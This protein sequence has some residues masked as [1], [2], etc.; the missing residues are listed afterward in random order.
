MNLNKKGFAI[1]SI[2]YSILILFLLL[3]FG[4][5][6]VLGSRKLIFDKMKHD[7]MNDLN[8][9]VVDKQPEVILPNLAQTLRKDCSEERTVGLIKDTDGSCYYQGT[10]EEVSN[11]FVWFAGHLWRVL[12]VNED[13]TLTMITQQPITTI[14][15]QESSFGCWDTQ[16]KYEASYINTWLN[17]VFL[18]SMEI[19]DQSRIQMSTY[20]I[21]PSD[22]IKA[23][24]TEQKVGI[25]DMDEY[26]KGGS[27]DSFLDIKDSFFIGNCNEYSQLQY[28]QQEGYISGGNNW[29]RS[30]SNNGV[31]AVI[32]IAN[33]TFTF[34][35]GTLENP[36][37]EKS[38]TINTSNIKVGEYIELPEMVEDGQT[39][40]YCTRTGHEG[41][42]LFRVVS[43]D[44][45]SIKVILNGVLPNTSAFDENNSPIYTSGNTIDTKV[46]AFA[47]TIDNQYRYTGNKSF[48]IGTYKEG[49]NYTVIQET[50]YTGTW[51][52][53][54]NVGLPVAG[55]MFSGNDIDLSTS[56]TKT[57]VNVNTIE[58]PTVESIWTMNPS[59][60]P[61]MIIINTNGNFSSGATFPNSILGVRPVLFLNKN[62]NF[63][64]G[65]GTAENPFVLE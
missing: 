10:N 39:P 37:R 59:D 21:G 29:F 11:N 23:I 1:S 48:N 9:D 6:G 36:Y 40:Q 5:L 24:Q 53:P 2:I 22:N 60:Q 27:T 57:F 63:T 4:I 8:G 43:K 62:L 31:R 15:A 17:D 55:E 16:E 28:V 25:L 12:T 26:T 35:D 13:D 64:S 42:C 46:T 34:G 50:K 47:N 38:G 61:L 14:Y 51:E 56:L 33:L 19:G 30:V 52:N 20:N 65:D 18:D 45:D 49:T 44:A 58:N 32:K 7:I 54:V 3:I 41:K